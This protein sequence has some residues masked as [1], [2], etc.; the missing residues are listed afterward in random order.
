MDRVQSRGSSACR[1]WSRRAHPPHARPGALRAGRGGERRPDD[2][3]FLRRPA[4]LGFMAI[5]SICVGASLPA[6][7]SSSRWPARGSSA[8]ERQPSTFLLL[9]G[10]VAV[11]GGMILFIR[12]WFGLVQTLR[13]R[14][15]PPSGPWPGCWPCGS[16]PSWWWPRS[17]AGRVL[18]RRPGRN[19]EP[20]HQPVP[21]RAGHH[22]LGAVRDRRRRAVA[23]HAGPLRAVLLD[24]GRVVR[25]R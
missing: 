1:W 21:L 22:R 4:L 2:W 23:E 8:R 7:P 12:V 6:R 20:P 25:P 14:P 3:S 10:V 17:S 24:A 9:P 19:D 16:S 5:L 15:G 18:L 11:Y 13:H